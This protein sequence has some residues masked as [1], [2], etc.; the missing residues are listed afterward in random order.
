MAGGW[1]RFARLHTYL[2]HLL[3]PQPP[4]AAVPFPPDRQTSTITAYR[5]RPHPQGSNRHAAVA[6]ETE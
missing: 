3:P 6:A 1:C 4:I 5:L 2:Q